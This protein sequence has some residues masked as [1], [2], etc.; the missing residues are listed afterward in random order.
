VIGERFIEWIDWRW[1]MEVRRG[2]GGRHALHE[3]LF[4]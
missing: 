3:W 2:T 4:F 1:K